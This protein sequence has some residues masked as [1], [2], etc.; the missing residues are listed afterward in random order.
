MHVHDLELGGFRTWAPDRPGHYRLKAELNEIGL[1]ASGIAKPF[2]DKIEVEAEAAV[3]GIKVKKIERFLGPLGFTSRGGEIELAVQRAWIGVFTQG[4]IDSRLAATGTLT[5]IDL[6]HP[7]FGSGQLA[8]GTLRLDDVTASYDAARQTTLTGDLGIDLQAS[9]LRFAGG[10]EVGFSRAGFV[11]PG[12]RVRTAP[13]LQP[14]VSVAPQLDVEGLRLG[15]ADLRGSIGTASVRL[16]GFSIEGQQPG[17]PF[18]VTGRVAAERIDLLL[19]QA[20]PVAIG[21]ERIEIDLA[22]TRLAFPPGRGSTPHRVA[23]ISTSARPR[24][25]TSSVS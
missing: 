25:V 4:R 19:P 21:A 10:S 16:S 18:F 20:A 15:G 3:T 6:A 23:N 13:G 14:Q 12:T 22:K 7:L 9:T 17:A 24:P 1:T 2:A 5:C 8:G 11:L